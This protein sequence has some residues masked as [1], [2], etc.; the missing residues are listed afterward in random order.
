MASSESQDAAAKKRIITHMNADH[1]DSVIRYAEHFCGLSSYSAR[2]A[3]IGDIS[4]DSLTVV[5][6]GKTHSIAFNPP[7]TSYREARER[8]VAMDKDAV[9][10]LGRSD[11]TVTEYRLPRG[12]HAVVFGAALMTMLS[13]FRAGNFVPGSYLYD[14]LLVYVPS[15]ASFCYKI[16]P[17]VFYPMISI[18]LA[19]AV[20]MARGRLRRHSV[21]PGTSLWWAWVTSNFIE[22]IGAMQRFDALVE[23][24][25]ADKEKQKH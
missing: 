20:H 13:F 22:G 8:V 14:Y 7:M 21:V 4:L 17:Y 23:R 12:F 18:H 10:A 15:F 2:N 3:K 25:K 19:E 24:K 1:H 11:I 9:T 16:Q 6:N 5:A